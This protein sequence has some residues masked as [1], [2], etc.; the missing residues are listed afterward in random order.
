MALLHRISD[1][2]AERLLDGRAPA[3][4]D[5]L[6]LEPTAL[7]VTALRA[8]VP[9]APPPG[10][11]A[12]LIGRLSDTALES[13]QRMAVAPTQALAIESASRG[14]GWRPRLAVVA[15]VAVGVALLPAAMAGLAFAGVTLPEPAREAM[16][17]LG[18]DLPNQ[19]VVDDEG[20]VGI[21]EADKADRA[22]KGGKAIQ[23]RETASRA[24]RGERRADPD[25]RASGGREARERGA[26]P[27]ADGEPGHQSRGQGTPQVVQ[28]APITPP[29]QGGTPPGQG[30]TSPSQ[31]KPQPHSGGP[32]PGQAKQAD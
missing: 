11:E 26:N 21:D 16:D 3:G 28:P 24:R 15:K 31:A 27:S 17:R 23:R 9:A 18:L 20:A 4:A 25:S 22:D 29:G 6:G 14:R 2:S 13:E 1:E 8:A 30:G 19:S 10:A 32:P 5:A 7:F 12:T